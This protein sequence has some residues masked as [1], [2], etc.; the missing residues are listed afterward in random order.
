MGDG[1]RRRGNHTAASTGA[2]TLAPP[3][4]QELLAGLAQL[5]ALLEQEDIEGARRYVRELEQRWPDSERVRHHARTLAPPTTRPRPDIKAVNRDRERGWLR[6]HAHE[7]PGC[8]IAVLGDQLVAADRELKVVVSR[9]RQDPAL[10]D[11]ILY[12]AGREPA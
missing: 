3:E 10:Q 1:L 4:D 6:A 2:A 9:I 5:R 7:Y 8:W 11:A 12:F